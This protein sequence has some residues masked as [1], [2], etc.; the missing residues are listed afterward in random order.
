MGKIVKENKR[1]ASRPY[2]DIDW[3][4]VDDHLIAGAPTTKIADALGIST[5]T[6][7]RRCE[8]EKNMTYTAYSQQK[9]SNGDIILQKAQFDKAIGRTDLGDNTLLI[10]L[11]KVRLDQ[12][13]SVT[14]NVTPQYEE[15]VNRL[16][17]EL[18]ECRQSRQNSSSVKIEENVN[19]SSND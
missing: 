10:W 13:E 7:Y 4:F 2:K 12:K 1:A 8:E 14:V 19:E 16:H 11:G 6:L 5:D 17:N 15:T 3:N 9:K 18:E